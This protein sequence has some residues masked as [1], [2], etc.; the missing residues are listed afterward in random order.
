MDR[1]DLL[2]MLARYRGIMSPSNPRSS[3]EGNPS[4][5]SPSP[6]FS[7]CV[8]PAMHV[9]AGR[10]LWNGARDQPPAPI[11]ITLIHGEEAQL[12][13]THSQPRHFL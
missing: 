10:N 8:G 11:L 5:Y 9:N 7:A 1:V 13:R 2:N 4:A 12:L 3:E 6:K